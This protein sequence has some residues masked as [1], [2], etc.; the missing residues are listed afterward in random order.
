MSKTL[1]LECFSD[2]SSVHRKCVLL[3]LKWL[4]YTKSGYRCINPWF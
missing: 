1:I 4:A 3:G 2:L